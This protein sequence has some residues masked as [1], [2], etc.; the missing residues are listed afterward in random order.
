M[1][2]KNILN[3]IFSV[4]YGHTTKFPE[5]AERVRNGS[6]TA[7][8]FF[9]ALDLKFSALDRLGSN[10]LVNAFRFLREAIRGW[11]VLPMTTQ[12]WSAFYKAAKRYLFA[13]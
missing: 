4:S 10:D 13:A 11:D 5:M 12:E 7:Q 1:I 2:N 3:R 8:R 9:S 6:R